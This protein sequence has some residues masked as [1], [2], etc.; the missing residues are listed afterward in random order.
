MTSKKEKLTFLQI[1][2]ND[3]ELLKADWTDPAKKA[4]R[5]RRL[6]AILVSIFR[7]LLLIGLCFIILMPIIQKVSF[8]I[9]APSDVSNPQ[10]IWVP[11]NFAFTN[12]YIAYRLLDY[13]NSL[14][15]TTI[16]SFGNMFLQIISTAIAGYA[17]A[18]LRFKGSNIL[19]A[20]V[21]FTIVVPY[22]TL[23]ISRKMFFHNTPFFGINLNNTVF[24]LFIM[25]AFG[26]G[27]RSAIFIYIFRQFFRNLPMELEESAQIDGAG[28]IRT[29]WSVMLPNARG[30]IVTVGL[31][32][33]VWQWNDYYF[34]SLFAIG[35]KMPLLTTRLAGATERIDTV[36]KSNIELTRLIGPTIL[37]NP[38]LFGLIAN[39]AALLMMLPLLIAYFRVQKLFV[40]SIERTGI[41]GM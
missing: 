20:I 9:R 35:R 34:A 16:M 17:F 22:E 24:S 30:A 33:F 38:L 2:K 36:I 32:S 19:F 39:T 29:F 7:A 31:F 13:W 27:I 10:V 11:Q 37:N 12:I 23:H 41:T 21:L 3:I 8:A 18:R 15:N 5:R 28:V 26:M 14:L 40:E 6:G 4:Y 1:L 25:S